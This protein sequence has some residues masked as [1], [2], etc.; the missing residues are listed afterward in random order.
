[1]FT[2]YRRLIRLLNSTNN[3]LAPDQS[4][5]FY[6]KGLSD[7]LKEKIWLAIMENG[8]EKESLTLSERGKSERAGNTR[9]KF[10]ILSTRLSV[11][12]FKYMVLP[13]IKTRCCGIFEC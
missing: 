13:L 4:R 3:K 2:I 7:S 5:M 11:Q 10:P 6:H 9:L 12:I 8:D 1:M